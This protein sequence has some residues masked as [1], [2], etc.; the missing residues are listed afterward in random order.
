VLK[1]D[2]GDAS[3]IGRRLHR[4][5]NR[6]PPTLGQIQVQDHQV[7][8]DC[9]GILVAAIQKGQRLHSV[10]HAVDLAAGCAYFQRF[11]GQAHVT[12][13]VIDDQQL[14]SGFHGLPPISSGSTKWD[15]E[16]KSGAAPVL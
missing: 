10:L 5:Q 7:G 12:Q 14:K 11:A 1:N 13:V 6:Q 4:R 2:D 8:A 16:L 15:G 9:I 3:Q